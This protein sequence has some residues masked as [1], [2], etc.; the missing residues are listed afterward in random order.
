MKKILIL[1]FISF[2]LFSSNVFAKENIYFVNSNG[3]EM[4]ELEYNNIKLI[5]GEEFVNSIDK[6]IYN[7][8][9]DFYS[10]KNLEIEQVNNEENNII[11]Y[12]TTYLTDY[13]YLEIKSAKMNGYKLLTITLNWRNAPKIRSYDVFG[14]RTENMSFT[15]SY[16][17]SNFCNSYNTTPNKVKLTNLGYGASIKLP[18]NCNQISMQITF[19]T[20]SSGT[21]YASYQHAVKNISL[22]SSTNYVFSPNGLGNVFLFNDNSLFD[23]MQ[24]VNINI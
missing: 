23:K 7:K 16:I 9:Q 8:Y 14:F 6:D 15:N 4:T 12:S 22:N 13:K 24:G 2:I 17:K 5:H 19:T 1:S 21:I 3:V 11:P 10:S 18:T 20:T